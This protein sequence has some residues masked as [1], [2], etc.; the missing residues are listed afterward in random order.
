M[1]HLTIIVPDG[2]STISGASC[3]LGAYDIF[4]RANQYW[5]EHAGEELF[6][7]QLAGVSKRAEF[8]NGLLIVK[9]QANIATISKTNII[10][11]PAIIF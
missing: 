8:N 4:T 9:P 10:I 7:I 1:K 2:Q 11:I 3:I 6:T 5:K